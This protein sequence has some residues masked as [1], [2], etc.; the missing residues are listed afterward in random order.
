MHQDTDDLAITDH[1]VEVFFDVLLAQIIGP[2]LAGLGES[3]LFARIPDEWLAR[4]LEQSET[5]LVDCGAHWRLLFP[6]M[7]TNLQTLRLKGLH[8][9]Q[10]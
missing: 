6:V 1:L 5:D 10:T 9:F 2:L 3:L 8:N 4:E 7:V